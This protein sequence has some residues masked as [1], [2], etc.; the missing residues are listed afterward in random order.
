MWFLQNQSESKAF[1]LARIW[2]WGAKYTNQITH[3]R[4]IMTFNTSWLK[5]VQDFL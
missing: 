1:K 5:G 3:Q 4:P 2:P